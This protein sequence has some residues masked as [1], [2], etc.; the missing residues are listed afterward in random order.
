MQSVAVQAIFKAA[1]NNALL[2]GAIPVAGAVASLATFHSGMRRMADA[3]VAA[4]L[5]YHLKWIH[6]SYPALLKKPL[7]KRAD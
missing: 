1:I 2:V 3:V 7:V 5:P 6:K 4:A